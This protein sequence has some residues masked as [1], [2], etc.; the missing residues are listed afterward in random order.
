MKPELEQQIDRKALDMIVETRFPTDGPF[1]RKMVAA[2]K[3][4]AEDTER[5]DWLLGHPG[6]ELDVDKMRKGVV[7]RW[8]VK[9]FRE[10]K[11]YIAYGKTQRECI[12]AAI[13]GRVETC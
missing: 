12:D 13:A 1:F 8:H 7:T 10:S 9:W 4:Y 6:A 11:W 3:G 5:L 2:M